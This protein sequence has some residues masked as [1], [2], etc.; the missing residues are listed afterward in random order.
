M[1]NIFL[2]LIIIDFYYNYLPNFKTYITLIQI[3]SIK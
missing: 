2:G 3:Y 1:L